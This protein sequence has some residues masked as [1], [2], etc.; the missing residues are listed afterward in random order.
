MKA[1]RANRVHAMNSRKERTVQRCQAFPAFQEWVISLNF[2]ALNL[3]ANLAEPSAS[4]H[5][6]APT[7]GSRGATANQNGRAQNVSG[8]C[9]RPMAIAIVQ[10]QRHRSGRP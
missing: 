6:N 3:A 4:L 5:R 2:P 9:P 1:V 7:S 10:T 8:M